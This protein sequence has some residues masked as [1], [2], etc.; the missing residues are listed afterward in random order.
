MPD[1][2]YDARATII[3]SSD[4][5]LKHYEH[6]AH[7][8]DFYAVRYVFAFGEKLSE[9]T[10]KVWGDKFGIR[11]FEAYGLD[12]ASVIASNTP[13]HYKQNT[14]GRLLPGIQYRLKETAGVTKLS[15][16]GENIMLGYLKADPL[17]ELQPL[18]DGW[19]EIQ[20]KIKI[21]DE[22]YLIVLS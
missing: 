13:M 6:N 9:E 19:F 12:E 10:R 18:K 21:N 4:T 16:N 22:G 8:Y 15:I 11:I 14:V 17:G 2:A 1:L 3:F 5:L 20:D 7:P